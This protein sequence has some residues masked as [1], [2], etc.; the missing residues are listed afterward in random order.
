MLL[1]NSFRILLLVASIVVFWKPF[2]ILTV[3]A[4]ALATLGPKKTVIFLVVLTFWKMILTLG[5]LMVVFLVMFPKTSRN[6]LERTGRT[7]HRGHHQ[8]GRPHMPR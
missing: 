1:I 7:P 6:I 3:L 2:L 8:F 5:I 4:I